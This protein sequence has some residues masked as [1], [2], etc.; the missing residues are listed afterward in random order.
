MLQT[1]KDQQKCASA[2]HVRPKDFWLLPAP[3]RTSQK[4]T[5]YSAQR[6]PGRHGQIRMR[7][8]RHHFVVTETVTVPFSPTNRSRQQKEARCAAVSS[9]NPD[10]AGELTTLTK[11]C[12]QLRTRLSTT[13]HL[14]QLQRRQ[15]TRPQVS[16]PGETS[17]Y[18][19]A[20]G[21]LARGTCLFRAYPVA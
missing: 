17:Q 9:E 11:C 18:R 5:R 13:P 21:V 2:P 7:Q 8:E 12:V 3:K 15:R 14:L 20:Q 4:E 6:K 19:P 1:W 16:E 10:G